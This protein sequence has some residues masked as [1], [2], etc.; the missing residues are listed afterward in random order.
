MK[1][2]WYNSFGN[3]EDVLIYGDQDTPVPESNEVLVR[4][5]YSA[6][7]PSDVKKRQ[8]ASPTL[9]DAGKVFPNSDGA[10]VIEAVGAGVSSARVGERVWVYNGQFGRQLGTSAEYISIDQSQAVPLPTNTSFEV[11]ACMGIPAMTAHRCVMSDGAVEGD[12]ILVTGGAGRVGHYAIQWAKHFG[13]TVIATAGSAASRKECQNAGADIVVGHPSEQS[14]SEILKFTNGRRVDRVVEGDFGVNLPYILDVI[15][16]SGVIAT[17]SSMTITEPSLPFRRMMFMDLN[18]RMVIVYAMP[19]EAK[20]AAARDIENALMQNAL[21][22]RIAKVYQL[23]DSA[24]A[25][26]KIESGQVYGCVLLACVD[27]R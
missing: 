5:E 6:V 23:K 7:N 18:I 20:R 26:R 19:K 22:H 11:G 1:A 25:H 8:G 27:T 3:A 24:A 12:I 16:T 10:G 9:L 2:V 13:A 14:V 21:Q 4:L 17:Y 15:K